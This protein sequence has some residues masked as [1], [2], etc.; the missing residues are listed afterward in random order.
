MKSIYELQQT[1]NRLRQITEVNSISPEDAFGL[2]SDVLEYLADM[3][4]NSEGLG[5]R[6]VYSSA[7]AMQADRQNPIG[8]NGKP[9]RM[10]QLVIICNVDNP[11]MVGNGSIYAYQKNEKTWMFIGNINNIS[12]EE[13][14]L[15]SETVMRRFISI[16]SSDIDKL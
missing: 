4:R 6:K 9:L 13:A 12:T 16:P 10:G 7:T 2:Q 1:A 15:I 8:S 11:S 14:E 5:I 3:E